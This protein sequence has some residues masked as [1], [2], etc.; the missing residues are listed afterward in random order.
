MLLFFTISIVMVV[1]MVLFAVIPAF[2]K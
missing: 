2:T 1:S